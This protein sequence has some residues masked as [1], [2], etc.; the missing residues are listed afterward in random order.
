M[1]TELYKPSNCTCK[2]PTVVVRNMIGHDPTCPVYVEWARKHF[3]AVE[4]QSELNEG[5]LAAFEK[6]VEEGNLEIAHDLGACGG[7]CPH[8]Q[9]ERMEQRDEKLMEFG[10]SDYPGEG[11]DV[12]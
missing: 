3:P 11:L 7:D 2:Y 5:E 10:D 4:L 12:P 8:C 1:P 9:Q 6:D